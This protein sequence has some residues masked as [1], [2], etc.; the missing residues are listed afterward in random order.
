MTLLI[1]D[2][3]F[4]YPISSTWDWLHHFLQVLYEMFEKKMFL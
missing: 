1:I 2:M 3:D 4:L